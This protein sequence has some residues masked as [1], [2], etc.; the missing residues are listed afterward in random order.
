MRQGRCYIK[1]GSH[2]LFMNTR[3]ISCVTPHVISNSSS[4]NL[5]H[6]LLNNKLKE[7]FFCVTM[8]FTKDFLP[9]KKRNA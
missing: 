8:F 4:M 5:F 1:F 6:F 3:Y 2:V 9:K 7:W